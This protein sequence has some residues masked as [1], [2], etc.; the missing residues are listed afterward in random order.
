MSGLN[1]YRTAGKSR[2]VQ[3]LE[4]DLY[5]HRLNQNWKQFLS[6]NEKLRKYHDPTT[7]HENIS[8]AQLHDSTLLTRGGDTS[9][10]S[11][12]NLTNEIGLNQT[13][14]NPISLLYQITSLEINNPQ[15][16]KS[17]LNQINKS[18]LTNQ[19]TLGILLSEI[20]KRFRADNETISEIISSSSKKSSNNAESSSSSPATS[21]QSEFMPDL[22]AI[23][24]EVLNT[25]RM[26]ST[27]IKIN[28]KLG[29]D[30]NAV[31]ICERLFSFLE[32]KVDFELK[33]PLSMI[34]KELGESKIGVL[35]M[36]EGSGL[37]LARYYSRRRRNSAIA[38][39]LS[40]YRML[41]GL[42]FKL[43]DDGYGCALMEAAELLI[44]KCSLEDFKGVAKLKRGMFSLGGL[45]PQDPM[46]EA[47]VYLH[48]RFTKM[49]EKKKSDASE[50]DLEALDC[51]LRAFI[52]GCIARSVW[53]PLFEIFEVILGRVS[54]VRPIIWRH[55]SQ[56]LAM[57]GEFHRSLLVL[58]RY[59]SIVPDDV[60][61]LMLASRLCLDHLVLLDDAVMFAELA[62]SLSREPSTALHLLG[63]AQGAK[64]GTIHVLADR[65]AMQMQALSS[66]GKS[67]ELNPKNALTLYHFATHLADVRELDQAF[68]YCR[69]SLVIDPNS[70]DA[71]M[72]L[73]LLFSC[74]RQWADAKAA[75]RCGLHAAQ[76]HL[77]LLLVLAR[78]L[79]V[80]GRGEDAISL[81]HTALD[82]WREAHFYLSGSSRGVIATGSTNG[83]DG[84]LIRQMALNALVDSHWWS[85]TIVRRAAAERV[86]VTMSFDPLSSPSGN[87]ARSTDPYAR[88]LTQSSVRR[89]RVAAHPAN[90]GAHSPQVPENSRLL[91]RVLETLR[92]IWLA[93]S[94]TFRL[95]G[96]WDDA[97]QCVAESELLYGE[98]ADCHYHRG[99]L[100][101]ARGHEEEAKREFDHAVAFDPGHE[102]S[103]LH[104][105][106]LA[107]GKATEALEQDVALNHFLSVLHADHTNFIGWY[108]VGT[109]L[110][111]RG[112]VKEAA[113]AFLLSLKL[114]NTAP[115]IPFLTLNRT[116]I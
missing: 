100:A 12:D 59:M 104:L 60:V 113:D 47:L 3:T 24:F 111:D 67:V 18:S 61:A 114:E 14:S 75:C 93:T 20:P 7:Y 5:K 73:A 89:R 84:G 9:N 80:T 116:G 71:W 98:S 108:H 52:L 85:W 41:L 110:E 54:N 48:Y 101:R 87:A 92:V 19:N 69:A 27:I 78:I 86:P 107:S 4:N 91:S 49:F 96:N 45:N 6:V 43:S 26:L 115:V 63:L 88:R 74:Q 56:C 13:Y 33:K 76:H 35:E 90:A 109:I 32:C 10:T 38:K 58:Q 30:E 79:V 53:D 44:Y 36:I 42:P 46:E 97:A 2:T 31:I 1:F 23:S 94:S 16:A 72:L 15:E 68:Q 51:I 8:E 25:I 112:Q 29:D 77:G 70:G 39:G 106:I 62:V 11:S 50:R 81:Y 105:G 37:F 21:N 66:L 95:M 64:V 99:R 34:F 40:I 17:I 102:K 82:V 65:Q 103:L 83:D 28:R 22:N 55:F 57:G